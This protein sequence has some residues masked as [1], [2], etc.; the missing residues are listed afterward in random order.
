MHVALFWGKDIWKT[1][2]SARKGHY[3]D[4]HHE[5]MVNHYSEVPWYW[6]IAV[7]VLSFVL[8]IIVVAKENVSMPIWAYIVSLL[9]G[10]A[11]APVVSA[12]R[13]NPDTQSTILYSRFGNGIATNNLSKMIGG[14]ALPGRPIGNMYFAAWSHTV[15]MNCLNLSS[16][17]KMGEYLKISPRVMFVSQ[18]WGTVFGAF[19]N[20]VVMISIVGNNKTLLATTDGNSSWSGASMQSYNTNASSWA[21]AKYL[22]KGDAP[23]SMV[24]IGIAIGAGLVVAHRI[25]VVVSGCLAGC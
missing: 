16:D 19:I 9:L 18:I 14:L 22:Y 1:Y 7:L 6:Y 2:K 4:K 12:H 5:H 13:N 3:N 11:I 25:F 8:G 10:S 21:L 15:I 23:Y 20:Y 17:L 24:P